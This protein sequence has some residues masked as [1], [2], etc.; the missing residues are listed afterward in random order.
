MSDTPRNQ[1][2]RSRHVQIWTCYFVFFG[3]LRSET[4]RVLL[5]HTRDLLPELTRFFDHF[6]DY[7][8]TISETLSPAIL[9]FMARKSRTVSAFQGLDFRSV[10]KQF[11]WPFLDAKSPLETGNSGG[12][13]LTSQKC[14]KK[15]SKSGSKMTQNGSQKTAKKR[16]KMDQEK[17]NNKSI[18]SHAYWY[19]SHKTKTQIFSDMRYIGI[20]SEI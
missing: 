14:I 1:G 2:V 12:W 10:L 8:W 16:R 19:P 9:H 7:F 13:K 17:W 3:P 15:D 18:L 6:L 20:F 11:L 5:F 4:N